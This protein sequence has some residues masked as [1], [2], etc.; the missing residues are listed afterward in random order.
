ML[1]DTAIAF[2][3]FWLRLLQ[4]LHR[5]HAEG[6]PTQLWN[7]LKYSTAFP[8]VIFAHFMR[9]AKEAKAGSP[10]HAHWLRLW[11]FAV[12]LNSSYSLFWDVQM[13]WGLFHKTP[14]VVGS[15]IKVHTLFH[16]EVV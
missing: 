14:Q 11:W 5:Y 6:G 10:A 15:F 7:A 3:P 12:V 8:V 9:A 1:W 2:V 13:D 4:C 16:I